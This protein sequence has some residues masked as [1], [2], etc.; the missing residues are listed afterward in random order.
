MSYMPIDREQFDGANAESLDH[1]STADHVLG[2]LGANPDTAF[3]ATEI[4][5][6]TDLDEGAVRTALSRLKDRD[7]VEHK[8][9]YWAISDDL[10]D[11]DDY[12]RAKTHYDDVVGNEA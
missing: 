12:E 4:V 10:D 3:K 7:L 1:L 9:P 8:E 11:Y 5:D 2:F 6:W